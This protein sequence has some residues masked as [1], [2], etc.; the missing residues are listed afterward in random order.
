ME[1]VDTS[2]EAL[3]VAAALRWL[4]GKGAR[5]RDALAGAAG[6]SPS[7]RAPIGQRW[8]GRLGATPRAAAIRRLTNF[9]RGRGFGSDAVRVAIAAAEAEARRPRR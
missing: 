6:A 1:A 8:F 7:D 4:R 9:L 2:D 5:E 3:A